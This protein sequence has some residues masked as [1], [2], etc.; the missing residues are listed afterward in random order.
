MGSGGKHCNDFSK[1]K[2][3]ASVTEEKVEQGSNIVSMGF[4]MSSK[5]VCDVM[6]VELSKIC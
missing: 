4:F 3:H 1:V 5:A 2:E 6:I